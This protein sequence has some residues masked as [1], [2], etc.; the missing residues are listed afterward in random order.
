[1]YVLSS[2][3]SLSIL[4]VLFQ[5]KLNTFQSGFSFLSQLLLIYHRFVKIPLTD[6]VQ[7]EGKPNNGGQLRRGDGPFSEHLEDDLGGRPLTLALT[8]TDSD[9]NDTRLQT[10]T[11]CSIQS[12]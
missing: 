4:F 12:P 3:I 11:Q 10:E 1:M 6:G 5:Q 9:T 7:R 8:P 2:T